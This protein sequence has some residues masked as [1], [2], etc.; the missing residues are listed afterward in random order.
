MMSMN[1]AELGRVICREFD[2]REHELE[3]LHS[4]IRTRV[5]NDR[6][7]LV[8]LREVDRANLWKAQKQILGDASSLLVQY[9]VERVTMAQVLKANVVSQIKEMD[10]WAKEREEELKGWHK[11]GEYMSK[12][13]EESK[14]WHKDEEYMAR[15]PEESKGGHKAGGYMVR[16]RTGR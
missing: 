13:P 12:K 4:E 7:E 6:E 8:E 1:L 11:A 9:R 2:Q 14:G 5:I 16:K 10:S 3:T 15:K